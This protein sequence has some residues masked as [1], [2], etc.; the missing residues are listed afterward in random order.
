MDKK[1]LGSDEDDPLEITLSNLFL[2]TALATPT[3]SA[4][5]SSKLHHEWI[6]RRKVL[7]YYQLLEHYQ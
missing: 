4:L 1:Q 6:F 5:W 2:K 3:G 7:G